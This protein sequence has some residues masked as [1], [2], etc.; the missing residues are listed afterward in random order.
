MQ[1]ENKKI[2]NFIAMTTV[3]KYKPES[4]NT[5]DNNI[6]ILIIKFVTVA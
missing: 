6:N 4:V 2:H 1:K 5:I 3:I